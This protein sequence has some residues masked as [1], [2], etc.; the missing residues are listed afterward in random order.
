MDAEVFV[1]YEVMSARYGGAH[2]AIS[3]WMSTDAEG[4]FH[5]EK[6]W[7]WVSVLWPG[8]W[9]AEAPFFRVFHKDYGL[10][11]W[12]F[13]RDE[14]EARGKGADDYWVRGIASPYLPDLGAL[15]IY[16]WES[17]LKAQQTDPGPEGGYH[18]DCV[19][20]TAAGCARLNRVRMCRAPGSFCVP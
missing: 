11:R 1:T 8:S 17:T 10:A 16:V 2:N 6:G 9:L 15:T 13:Y 18:M 12:D 14:K 5:F 20:L 19:G 3:R 4:R 7:E